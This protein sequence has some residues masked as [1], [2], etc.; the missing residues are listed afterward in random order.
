MFD[1]FGAVFGAHT[2]LE[3]TPSASAIV[4]VVVVDYIKILP[5]SP[6]YRRVCMCVS[7]GVCALLRMCASVL[8]LVGHILSRACEYYGTHAHTPT[9]QP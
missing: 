7:I 2:W 8:V 3:K 6:M 4:V 9:R 5:Y 1:G